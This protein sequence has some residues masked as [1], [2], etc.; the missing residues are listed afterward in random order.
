EFRSLC[1]N[2]NRVDGGF[3]VFIVDLTSQSLKRKEKVQEQKNQ[4]N[5]G[6][7]TPVYVIPQ[8]AYKG[9]EEGHSNVKTAWSEEKKEKARNYFS[10]IFYDED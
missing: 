2:V 4:E 9:M 6:K 8:N 10:K 5:R 7:W 1:G 3:L